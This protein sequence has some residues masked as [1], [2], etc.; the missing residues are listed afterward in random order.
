[1]Y[2][3]IRTALAVK[4]PMVTHQGRRLQV[5]PASS[6]AFHVGIFYAAPFVSLLMGLDSDYI[7]Q[8]VRV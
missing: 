7:G 2:Q 6:A 1:M 8:H 5:G 3:V 4:A